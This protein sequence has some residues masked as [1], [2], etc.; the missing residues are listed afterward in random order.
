MNRAQRRAVERGKV[1]L[2]ARQELVCVG[3]C[4]P[5]GTTQPLFQRCLRGVYAYEWLGRGA[6]GQQIRL[7]DE[8]DH[9]ASSIHVPDAR[10]T[11]VQNF[12]A[13]P[14]EPEWLWMVDDDATFA[15]NILDRFMEVAH[16]DERPIVGALAYGVHPK[17]DDDGHEQFNQQLGADWELFPTIYVPNDEG[18]GTGMWMDY[19]RDQL[20]PAVSTGCHCFVVH[21][22]VLADPR[23]TEE[24]HPLPWFHVQ[25]TR[26]RVIS[27]DQF[28]FLKAGALGYPLHIDTRIKTGHIKS[29]VAEEDLYER[30]RAQHGSDS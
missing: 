3:F 21:R 13:H 15:P 1:E 17:L 5:H 18:T 14:L 9:E 25:Y 11:I 23:W 24:P 12:L 16:A 22:R 28:F 30:Q 27:E 10:C 26:D 8:F 2:P 4:H 20:F 7:I 29:Y 6:R 19:P